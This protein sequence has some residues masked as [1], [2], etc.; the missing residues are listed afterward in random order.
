MFG[1]KSVCCKMALLMLLM[2]IW[3]CS[4]SASESVTCYDGL[5]TNTD[6][7]KICYIQEPDVK[8]PFKEYPQITY[9]P[10]DRIYITASGCV[11]TGGFGKT[12][13]RY[14]TPLGSSSN[15]LYSGLVYLPGVWPWRGGITTYPNTWTWDG[16]DVKRIGDA[17]SRGSQGGFVVA[18]DQGY[19]TNWLHLWLG[20]ED[21]N[22]SDNGYSNHDDGVDNQCP[23]WPDGK[24]NNAYVTVKIITP[25]NQQNPPVPPNSTGTPPW[26]SWAFP[27]PVKRPTPP[28]PFRVT[29]TPT[30][31][32]APN[33]T[34]DYSGF[35]LSYDFGCQNPSVSQVT[36]RSTLPIVLAYGSKYPDP[37]A[38][39]ISP[40]QSSTNFNGNCANG[41]WK[42]IGPESGSINNN[43][44]M[45][46]IDVW[47]TCSTAC[48]QQSPLTSSTVTIPIAI[49]TIDGHSITVVNGGG[50]GGPNTGPNS[51]A[52]HTDAVKAGPWETFKVEWVDAAHF[53]L[54]TVNGNYITAVKGGGIGGPNDA[55]S[56]VHTDASWVGAW[57]KLTL[58]Y[59][60]SDKTATIQTPNGRYLT[61]VNGGGFGGLNN[62]PVHT[63]A[64]QLGP[65]ETFSFVILK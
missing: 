5:W 47:W 15:F 51:V 38:P 6:P 30:F 40:N 8:V 56:P 62:V 22:Y 52:I 18:N 23:N 54:K 9:K 57:E 37:F 39:A 49:K 53:A 14:N 58:N 35:F 33:R 46:N 16:N 31:T 10:G 11:Q 65:W 55:T 44:Y 25:V 27:P 26:T 7:Y 48:S 29:L 45:F 12:W 50:L 64:K 42:A 43:W 32:T 21:N 2:V 24:S 4:S 19:G 34:M 63:D 1:L 13:K 36:N 60:S 28:N 41:N 17:E 20:Y 3:V 59:N 61:A